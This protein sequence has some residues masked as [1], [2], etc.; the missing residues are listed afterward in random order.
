MHLHL[1]DIEQLSLHALIIGH[2]LR[3][4][5]VRRLAGLDQLQLF[6]FENA[7][8][9]ANTAWPSAPQSTGMPTTS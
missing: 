6:P 9:S 7:V 2:A 3:M 5:T 4:E 8:L 1:R